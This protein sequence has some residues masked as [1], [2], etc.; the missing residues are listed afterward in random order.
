MTD[1]LPPGLAA[2]YASICEALKDANFPVFPTRL[3]LALWPEA[4]PAAGPPAI[5]LSVPKSGTYFAEALF[6]RLGYY[7]VYVHAMDAVCNDWRFHEV[8]RADEIGLTGNKPIAITVLSRLIL[9]GQVIV[10]HC[11]RTPAIEA[12]LAG[13]KKIYLYRDLR[14][15]FVSYAR[16]HSES[17]IPAEEMPAC[18]AEF[19]RDRGPEAKLVIEAVSSWRNAPDVMAIDFAD[20]TS[21]DPACRE[22]L[23]A[24][25]EDFIG[26]PRERVTAALAAVPDDPTPTKSSGP[27]SQVEGA[28]NSECEAWFRD[29]MAGT[30][31]VPDRVCSGRSSTAAIR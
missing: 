9:P 5:I 6:K 13:F 2:T 8:A 28:W 19:C 16:E 7:G 10:S 21:P 27:H 12:A 24:R 3:G 17:A 20:L 26:W 18:V 1:A 14:E 15:V 4:D 30:S 25:F 29:N 31:V 11:S 23:A 22:R